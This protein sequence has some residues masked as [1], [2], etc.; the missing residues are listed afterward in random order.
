MQLTDNEIIKLF[1]FKPRGNQIEIVKAIIE[2]FKNRE[3]TCNIVITNR[4]SARV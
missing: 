4:W 1:P 2:A 3:E